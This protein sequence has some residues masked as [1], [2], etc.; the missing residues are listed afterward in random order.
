MAGGGWDAGVLSKGSGRHP[1]DRPVLLLG[2]HSRGTTRPLA[3]TAG[4]SKPTPRIIADHYASLLQCGT[5]RGLLH[6]RHRP[7]AHRPV[8]H[9]D[10]RRARAATDTALLTAPRAALTELDL[11]A[12]TK[13]EGHAEEAL[14][15]IAA[16]IKISWCSKPCVGLPVG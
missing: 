13:T 9:G 11:A 12:V 10:L 3:E 14:L 15:R 1:R 5:P 7:H 4:W 6:R 16:S 8:P 2:R